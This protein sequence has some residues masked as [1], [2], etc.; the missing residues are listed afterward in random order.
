MIRSLI[1]LLC[2]LSILSCNG[3]KILKDEKE[4]YANK[5]SELEFSFVINSDDNSNKIDFYLNSKDSNINVMIF[6]NG[7]ILKDFKIQIDKNQ[8]KMFE[9]IVKEQLILKN[10]TNEAKNIKG[11]NITFSVF[12]GSSYLSANYP[13]KMNFK[14]EVS[15]EFNEFLSF[16]RKNKEINI[17]LQNN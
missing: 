5:E 9:R 16:L 1:Y 15:A 3:D 17:F 8:V 11:Y 13:K 12:F 4:V 2:T 10:F 14:K 6:K 7:K